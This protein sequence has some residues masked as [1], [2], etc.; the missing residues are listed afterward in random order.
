MKNEIRLYGP[1]GEYP[2]ISAE[3]I[4]SQIPADAKEITVRINSPGGSVADGLAIYNYLRDHA[5]KVT[6]V[7]DGFAASAASIVMLAGDV[8]QVHRGSMVMVHLPSVCSAG[9]A[10]ELRKTAD[11]LDTVTAAMLEIYKTRTGK[12]EEEI[13]QLVEGE[14]FMTGR[15]AVALGFA[16]SISDDLDDNRIAAMAE[17]FSA[18]KHKE[19]RKMEEKP[20][21]E[22]AAQ[23]VAVVAEIVS[24][25]AKAVMEIS[26][27]LD[28]TAK[29]RDEFRALLA[30]AEKERD[31][32]KGMLAEAKARADKA[33]AALANPA[34]IDAAMKPAAVKP[35]INDAEADKLDEQAKAG[36]EA[37]KPKTVLEAYEAMAPGA[38]RQR[39]LAKNKS[40]IYRLMEERGK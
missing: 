19:T 36:A 32:V 30:E 5:A 14:T 6:T 35:G 34:F 2:G 21:A 31:D 29:E 38:E 22:E 10:G 18:A 1:I 37:D 24:A 40:E 26:A 16:D 11:A 12:D 8:R 4:A 15:E 17:I 33:E 28:A 23:P 25:E 13:R 9:N 27:R 20:K 39:F 7:V 3:E